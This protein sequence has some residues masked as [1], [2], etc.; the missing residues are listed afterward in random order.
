VMLVNAAEV[1]TTASASAAVLAQV[2]W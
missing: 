2:S 1:S